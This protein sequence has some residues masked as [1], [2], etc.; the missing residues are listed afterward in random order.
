MVERPIGPI[1]GKGE[2]REDSA[3]QAEGGAPGGET[4]HAVAASAIEGG[5]LRASGSTP[6][7]GGATL[8]GDAHLTAV[9]R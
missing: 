6:I 7:G 2:P 4:R 9:A 3:V 1:K 8:E 5:T